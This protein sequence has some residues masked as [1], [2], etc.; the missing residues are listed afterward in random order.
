MGA[1]QMNSQK[2]KMTTNEH[3]TSLFQQEYRQ[4]RF[5]VV[6]V[7][8]VMLLT[9][10]LGGTFDVY[11]HWHDFAES[12][13]DWELDE[14]ALG[15]TSLA[16]MMIWYIRRRQKHAEKIK[17]LALKSADEAIEAN[18][19]KS[20][21][22]ALMSHDSVAEFER[23]GINRCPRGTTSGPGSEQHTGTGIV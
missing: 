7:V 9:V 22:L 2:S 10:F 20:D 21:F 11:E 19:A 15:F 13:E 4:R 14:I 23:L 1:D 12:H 8:G 16:F 6:I 3:I 5:D 18:R 17:I